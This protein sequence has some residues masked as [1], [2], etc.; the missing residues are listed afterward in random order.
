MHVHVDLDL[1][2]ECKKGPRKREPDLH[3]HVVEQASSNCG[4]VVPQHTVSLNSDWFDLTQSTCLTFHAPK[5]TD[6]DLCSQ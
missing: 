3:V 5:E 1:V 4:G 6:T 2:P